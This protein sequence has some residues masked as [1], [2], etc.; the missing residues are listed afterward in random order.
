MANGRWSNGK[1]VNEGMNSCCVVIS[2]HS[3]G[4]AAY[5]IKHQ[6]NGFICEYNNL[7]QFVSV[8]K[9]NISNRK[10][11]VEIG[12]NAYNTIQSKWNARIA[13]ERFHYLCNNIDD[14]DSVSYTSGPLSSA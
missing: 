7:E 13:A 14:I 2:S 5:L 10:L 11:S 12:I 1:I 3:V 4:S 6:H 8:I 9:E